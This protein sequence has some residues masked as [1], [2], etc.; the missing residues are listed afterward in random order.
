MWMSHAVIGAGRLGRALGLA[1]VG[2]GYEVCFGVPDPL[3]HADLAALGR[4]P[5]VPV[6]AAIDRAD[7]VLLATPF[8]AAMALVDEV[9]DW[10]NR[11][12]VDAT[13]PVSPLGGGLL[14]GSVTSG[15]QQI[16]LRARGA[17]VVK[18]F[19][20]IGCENYANPKTK[21]GGLFLPVAGDD[22]EARRYVL[23][24]AATLGFDAVD[25]GPLAAALYIE[26]LAMLW[27]E[28]AKRGGHGRHFGFVRQM[29]G[30]EA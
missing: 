4:T 7:V 22:P 23:A 15:A 25:L 30:S 10:E 9:S 28:M 13:N 14:F 16:E 27:I 26:P 20:V 19:N 2:Q 29:T 8:T 3:R 12:L 6:K 1:L 24:L 18:A 21:A 5:V 17:R 11:L